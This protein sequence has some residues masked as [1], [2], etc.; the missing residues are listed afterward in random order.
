MK[1]YKI[2]ITIREGCDEYW[3]EITASGNSGCDQ[4]LND[5]KQ[6]IMDGNWQDFD[7][8]LIGYTDK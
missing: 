4:V 7:I 2:E 3:E 8:R 1:E 6:C 5:V